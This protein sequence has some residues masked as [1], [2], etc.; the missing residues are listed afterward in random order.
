MT[1][2]GPEPDGTTAREL[3]D[4]GGGL[5]GLGAGLDVLAFGLVRTWLADGVGVLTVGDGSTEELCALLGTDAEVR[6]GAV[7]AAHDAAAVT[8]HSAAAT[9]A[10]ERNRRVRPGPRRS[11]V[12]PGARR[13]IRL[14]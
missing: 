2:T 5:D 11:A 1:I 13:P 14:P 9:P 8:A 3:R 4:D 12:L 10:A 6:A 7:D